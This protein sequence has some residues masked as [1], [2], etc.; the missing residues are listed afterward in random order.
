MISLQFLLVNVNDEVTNFKRYSATKSNTCRVTQ[1]LCV[2]KVVPVLTFIISRFVPKS[3]CRLLL[4]TLP[5]VRHRD[6]YR[7]LREGSHVYAM[8]AVAVS[9]SFRV[10]S[11]PRD[12][13]KRVSRSNRVVKHVTLATAPDGDTAPPGCSRYEVRI[14]KP[15]GLVLEEDKTGKIF[16][17]EIIE[18]SNAAKAGLISVGDQLLATSAMVFN[19]T[20]EYGGV[21]VRKGEET[22]MFQVLGEDF[23]T[24][25]AAIG[26]VPSQRLVTL[27]F[28]KCI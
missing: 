13:S 1:P 17:V 3:E 15:L 12:R 20:E 24:V 23:K 10:A 8:M 5:C 18:D 22:I 7:H 6:A 28:Q 14:K 4:S 11:V 26:T 27:K 25:M 2:L 16:V 21:S 9:P 19:S